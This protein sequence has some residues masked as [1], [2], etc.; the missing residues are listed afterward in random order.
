M[1][2]I[3]AILILVFSTLTCL[4]QNDVTKFLGIPVDGTKTEMLDK[5]E[6]K[7]FNVYRSLARN[8]IHGRFNGADVKIEIVTDNGKVS[9]IIIEDIDR[10]TEADIKQRFNRLCKQFKENGKYLVLDDFTIPENENISDNMRSHNK[11]YEAV[12]FQLPEGE[13]R[14]EFDSKIIQTMLLT[15]IQNE[16]KDG[17]GTSL[18]QEIKDL[19]LSTYNLVKNKPVWFR[20]SKASGGYYITMFYDNEYNRPHGEDL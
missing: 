4:S 5:L 15:D 12:F 16:F 17:E 2:R 8:A 7:G 20:I 13:D 9:R 18:E 14:K 19:Y 10:L 1:R 6:D 11:R 3:F